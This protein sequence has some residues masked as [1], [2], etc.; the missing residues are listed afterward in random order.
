MTGVLLGV[1]ADIVE[2]FRHMTVDVSGRSI[3]KATEDIMR[4]FGC[5][6]ARLTWS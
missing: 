4:L 5:D 2:R 1:L 3:D 6:I